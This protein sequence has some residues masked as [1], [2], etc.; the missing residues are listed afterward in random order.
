[1]AL[2]S[3]LEDENRRLRDDLQ[4]QNDLDEKSDFP[5]SPEI[6]SINIFILFFKKSF[7]FK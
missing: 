4:H 6:I 1:M 3:K 7:V 5:T 2:V